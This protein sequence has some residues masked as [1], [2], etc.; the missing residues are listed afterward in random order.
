[1][2]VLSNVDGA[3]AALNSLRTRVHVTP[4]FLVNNRTRHLSVAASWNLGC[5]ELFADGASAVLIANDDILCAPVTV[6]ALV[7]CWQGTGA[8]LVAARNMRDHISPEQ[9]RG[10]SPSRP[11]EISTNCSFGLFL[12]PRATW[13]TAGRFDENFLKAYFEDADYWARGALLGLRFL[14]TSAAP[15]YHFGGLTAGDAENQR[16]GLG[17]LHEDFIANERY[18]VAKW[19]RPP[20]HDPQLMRQCY[21][22][23]P[24]NDPGLT[25]RDVPRVRY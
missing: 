12:L 15:Y 20:V 6:D 10:Y 2:P 3:M 17:V 7:D 9:I 25:P 5:E 23:T 22:A 4:L 18:F 13:E 19:G 8:G 11:F 21:Y 14:R 24:F 16:A 1:M